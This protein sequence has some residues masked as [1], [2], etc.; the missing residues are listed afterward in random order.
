VLPL[1]LARTPIDFLAAGG[2]KWLCA[3][4]GVG[5]FYC[6][7]SR[8]D[9]LRWAPAGW[10]GYDRSEDMLLKGEGHFSYDLPLRPAAQRFE[11]GTPN[12]LGLVGLA[13][14]LGEVERVG[15][16]A[17]WDRAA[18]LTDRLRDGLRGRGYAVLS[19]AGE[20]V[21][22]GIVTFADPGGDNERVRQSLAGRGCRVSYPDGKLRVSPHYWTTD[23]EVD[24]FLE[25]L[26]YAAAG[27]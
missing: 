8:L 22:S 12:L 7:R 25:A 2:H 19:P 10:L 11:G 16:E 24:A 20:K 26:A 14:A 17:I 13:A 18:D 1:S 5:L 21:R 27:P 3:P 9:L 6:R 15:V 4:P 23:A